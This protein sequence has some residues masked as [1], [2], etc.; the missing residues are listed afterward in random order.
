MNTR[1]ET[2]THLGS[3]KAESMSKIDIQKL[4]SQYLSNWLGIKNIC[5]ILASWVALFL[6]HLNFFKL[7][8]M[9]HLAISY[10]LSAIYFRYISE[11]L[12]EGIHINIHPNRQISE[13]F[14]SWFLAPTM[15]IPLTMIRKA[16]FSHHA[17]RHFFGKNDADTRHLNIDNRRQF[18]KQILAD[19]SGISAIKAY[20]SLLLRQQDERQQAPIGKTV[21]QFIPVVSFNL[22]LVAIY[23][24]SEMYSVLV[25]HYLAVTTL[26]AALSRIRA[27]GQHLKLNENGSWSSTNSEISRS[28]EGNFLDRTLISS[29]LMLNHHEHHKYPALPYR[30]LEVIKNKHQKDINVY[31]RSHMPILNALIRTRP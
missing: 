31:L 23:T 2:L 7:E 17:A 6:F 18:F 27:Y 16:H 13:F 29:K 24:L 9:V 14:S 3:V 1:Q 19:L 15:G 10:I 21:R 25:A 8:I 28:I 11:W 22:V 12:H 5:L 30:A 20:L 4:R 26:Y